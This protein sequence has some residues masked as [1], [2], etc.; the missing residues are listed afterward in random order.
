M[1]PSHSVLAATWIFYSDSYPLTQGSLA[2]VLLACG[3]LLFWAVG[4][5]CVLEAPH[6][7]AR[8]R[9]RRGVAGSSLHS[10]LG[11]AGVPK[12]RC[13]DRL[14]LGQTPKGPR[15]MGLRLS[16][17]SSWREAAVLPQSV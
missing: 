8:H 6:Q 13:T 12:T 15:L 14:H 10:V 11:L 17:L 4:L 3:D 9:A 1:W 16:E 7:T 5:S 2:W